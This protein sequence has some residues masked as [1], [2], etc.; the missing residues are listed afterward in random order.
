MRA[1]SLALLL[2]ATP[3][4]AGCLGLGGDDAGSGDETVQKQQA[5]VGSETGGIQGVVTD[6]AVQPIEG[7]NVTLLETDQTTQTATDGS[8]AFSNLD[9]G[10]YTIAVRAEGFISTSN[11][12]Q[13]RAN[14]VSQADFILSPVA[15]QEAFMQQIEDSA[16]FECGVGVGWNLTQLPEV[17]EAPLI[18]DPR[19][20]GITWATCATLN[21]EGNTTND[22]FS[23][24]IEFE[25]PLTELVVEAQWDP[26]SPAADHMWL[27]ADIQG[28]ANLTGGNATLYQDVD[29]SSPYKHV[30]NNTTLE[31]INE[32]FI[33][34]CESGSSDGD[35]YCG[36][37]FR[38]RGWPMTARTFTATDCAPTPASG[39]APIQQEVNYVF[40]AFYNQPAPEDYSVHQGDAS[41]G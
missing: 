34:R 15:L 6:T 21:L 39:C 8:Y 37:N 12:T 4:L 22:D 7:A 5:E 40:T 27:T 28:F 38:D 13:L 18:G 35:R 17:P 9:P 24:D 23:E 3:L 20:F 26:S 2:L 30:V 14:Q 10:T 16:F 25:A 1:A 11:E 32:W 19:T 36:Y 41:T 33:R 31:E 29:A